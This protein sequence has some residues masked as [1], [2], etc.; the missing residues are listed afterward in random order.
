M[1]R[2]EIHRLLPAS[3]LVGI[4]DGLLHSL[5]DSLEI[6]VE[7]KGPAFL[8]GHFHLHG[9]ERCGDATPGD[10]LHQ[11]GP[12]IGPEEGSRN[13]GVSDIQQRGGEGLEVIRSGCR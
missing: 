12:N 6:G 13:M 5:L 7:V 9:G 10:G 1:N 4:L 8:E 11:G 3:A 2:G